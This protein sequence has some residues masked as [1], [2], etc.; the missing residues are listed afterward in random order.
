RVSESLRNIHI[1][2]S[3]NETTRFFE[4][5]LNGENVEEKIRSLRIANNV[6]EVSRLSVVRELMVEKQRVIGRDKG[7]VMDGRDIGTVVFPEAELKIFMTADFEVRAQRR[8]EELC[9]QGVSITLDEV[10]DNLRQRDEMDSN[11]TVSP[12]NQ[13]EDALVLDTSDMT[14]DE[15]LAWVCSVVDERM[16]V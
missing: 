10:K 14:K 1:T 6:S 13:A 16:N 4:T 9:E 2:F 11:R 15:E 3:L 12:L 5:Y 8:Y 7:I